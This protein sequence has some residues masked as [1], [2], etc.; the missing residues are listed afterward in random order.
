M[1]PNSIKELTSEQEWLQAF[2]I[3]NQL[4]THLDESTYIETLREMKSQGYRL[5]SLI[6]EGNVRAVAGIIPL[7]SLYYG[8]YVWVHDLVTDTQERSKGNGEKLL[9][10]IQEWAK[11][12]GFDVVALSSGLQRQDAHRFYEEKMKFDKASYVFKINL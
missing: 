10:F 1:D 3:M 8:R 7:T 12:E 11:T 4:R 9:S 6:E 5:F 2:P